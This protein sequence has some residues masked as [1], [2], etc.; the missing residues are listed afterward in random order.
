MDED[1]KLELAPVNMYIL[2]ARMF[3]HITREVEAAC[4]E[5]G[6]AAVREGVRKFGE[7][8]GRDIAHRAAAMGHENDAA[9]YL[10]CYDMGRSDHF[11]SE[12]IVGET[13]VEQNFTDCVFAKTFTDDG[14][15]QWGIHYCQMID[16]AIARG[17]N[18]QFEC[19]HDK[20]FF[21]DGCCHFKF[22]M[23]QEGETK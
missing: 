8:R 12:D 18:E 6:V 17:Y 4:G 1:K 13:C 16:P 3:A 7:E 14:T 15:Q 9:H 2:F 21:K 23:Q 22:C 20:H 11:T 10:S 19:V 5:Q